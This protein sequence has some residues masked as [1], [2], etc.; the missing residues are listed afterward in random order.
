VEQYV[1]EHT[2]AEFTHGICPDC[3]KKYYPELE[4]EVSREEK[5]DSEIA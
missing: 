3:I 5:G 2:T 4:E 1:G